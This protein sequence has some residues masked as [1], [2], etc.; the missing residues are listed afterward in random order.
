MKKVTLLLIAFL[1]ASVSYSQS[2]KE[3][4]DLFQAAVGMQKKEAVANFVHPAAAQKDAF[5]KLYDEYETA[6]KLNGQQRIKV[7]EQY[8]NQFATMTDAQAEAWMNEVLKLQAATDGLIITY[9]NKIK[10]ATSPLVATQ[11][12]QIENYF[13]SV[14]RAKILDAVPFVGEKK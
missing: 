13:L 6:R 8:A 11:F 7:L 9:Y 3:E 2:N 1:F 4:I 10:K 5:W 12:Y 14:V